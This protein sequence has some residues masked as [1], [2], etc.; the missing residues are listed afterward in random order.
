MESEI[1]QENKNTQIHQ[2]RLHR[3]IQARVKF[4][5]LM[6][7]LSGIKKPAQVEE[8]LQVTRTTVWK[9]KIKMEK[10]AIKALTSEPAGRKMNGT[11]DAAEMEMEIKRLKKA[12]RKAEKEKTVFE[13]KWLKAKKEAITA[14][15]A[16][17]FYNEDASK[18]N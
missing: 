17:R 1:L 8:E 7:M 5:V 18:K 13:A 15:R 11:V 12:L 14:G 2:D 9:W 10:A 4:K 6:E 3:K 16:F